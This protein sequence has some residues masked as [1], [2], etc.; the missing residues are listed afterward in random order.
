MKRMA[1]LLLILVLL[2]SGCSREINQE[3]GPEAA[4]DSPPIGEQ[5]AIAFARVRIVDATDG[6]EA[7]VE[8]VRA[9][10]AFLEVGERVMLDLP[11]EMICD[12]E[13]QS[14]IIDR[15]VETQ[16]SIYDATYNILHADNALWKGENP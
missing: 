7:I 14:Q 3:I 5:Y 4:I 13:D 6:I 8:E 1:A 10:T 2:L 15:V 12:V 16:S 11:G 9:D